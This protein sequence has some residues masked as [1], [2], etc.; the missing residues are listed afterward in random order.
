MFSLQEKINY[1]QIQLYTLEKGFS[2][3]TPL[4]VYTE[5]NG[6]KIKESCL[7]AIITSTKS[8]LFDIMHYAIS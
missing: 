3:P 1:D 4:H 8:I 2:E 5:E 7:S 6:S